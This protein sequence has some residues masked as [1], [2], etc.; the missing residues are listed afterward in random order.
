M[1]R[2]FTQSS[3]ISETDEINQP[4]QLKSIAYNIGQTKLSTTQVNK[5]LKDPN[6]IIR[7]K[8]MI[9]TKQDLDEYNIQIKELMERELLEN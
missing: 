9:Y 8:P 7:V 2:K 3:E 4:N 5:F 6:V 1:R